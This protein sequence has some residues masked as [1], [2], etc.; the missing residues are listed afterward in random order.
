VAAIDVALFVMASSLR[1]MFTRFAA[2]FLLDFRPKERREGMF[3]SFFSDRQKAIR[4]SYTIL[5][6]QQ[7]ERTMRG[8]GRGGMKCGGFIRRVLYYLR[9]LKKECN[10]Q[11]RYE[12]YGTV[13]SW[14]TKN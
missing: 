13:N 12:Q 11:R 5:R 10:G 3:F 6:S 2:D 14:I 1:R 8:R 9:H 4:L 7:K